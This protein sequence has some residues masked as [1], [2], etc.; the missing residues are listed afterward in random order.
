MKDDSELL[1]N[2]MNEQMPDDNNNDLHIDD[3]D[4]Q[5]EC[6]HGYPAEVMP[7]L[8]VQPF[9][10]EMLRPDDAGHPLVGL[11]PI[12]TGF[13]NPAGNREL[14]ATL[15]HIPPRGKDKKKKTQK[16]LSV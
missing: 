13:F 7:P 16:M 2:F 10:Y 5:Q 6:I 14:E 1:K 9:P 4:G 12:A 8:T 15:Y 3:A 11:I